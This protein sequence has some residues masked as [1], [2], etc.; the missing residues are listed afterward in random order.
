MIESGRGSN[1]IQGTVSLDQETE[2]DCTEILPG[3]HD[4][5]RMKKWVERRSDRGDLLGDGFVHRIEASHWTKEDA[6]AL[7]TEWEKCICSPGEIRLSHPALP[8]GSTGPYAKQIRRTVLPWYVRIEEDHHTLEVLE[9]GTWEDLA[10]AHRDLMPGP[11]TPSGFSV[12]YGVP[13]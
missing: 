1:Q 7:G 11:C 3:L 6:R 8:H 4:T 10:A 12:N 13:K 5:D 2:N 9:S